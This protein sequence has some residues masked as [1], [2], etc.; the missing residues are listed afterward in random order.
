MELALATWIKIS[1][2]H[3]S[4]SQW[5]KDLELTF[6]SRVLQERR[7]ERK[8]EKSKY[9]HFALEQALT[10]TPQSRHHPLR[11]ALQLMA[12]PMLQQH[13]VSEPSSCCSSYLPTTP[14]WLK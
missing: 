6:L 8:K 14:K 7:K 1:S 12:K 9:T 10:P 2:T 11:F 3:I 5:S 13:R 4:D